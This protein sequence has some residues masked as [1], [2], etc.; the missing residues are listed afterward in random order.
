MKVILNLNG[1]EKNFVD[2]MHDMHMPALDVC[3]HARPI[4]PIQPVVL[5]IKTLKL[6]NM[7]FLHVED[8]ILEQKHAYVHTHP[9]A[10]QSAFDRKLC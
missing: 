6:L 3:M 4:Q 8:V 5:T 9:S 7:L 10:M 2:D 1:D